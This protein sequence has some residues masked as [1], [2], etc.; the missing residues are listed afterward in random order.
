ML[1]TWIIPSGNGTKNS[2]RLRSFSKAIQKKK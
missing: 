1:R 2:T